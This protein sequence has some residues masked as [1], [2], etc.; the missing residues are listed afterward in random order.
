ME[1]NADTT[2]Q[3]VVDHL[4]ATLNAATAAG[5]QIFPKPVKTLDDLDSFVNVSDIL[6]GPGPGSGEI[7]LIVGTVET[8]RGTMSGEDSISRLPVEVVV[9]F[10]MLRA[11]LA[12]EKAAVLEAKRY[13]S[14]VQQAVLFDRS[15]NGNCDLIVWNG[16]IIS[17]TE[18]TGAVRMIGGPPNQMFYTVT[19]PVECGWPNG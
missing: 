7:G 15:R 5:G 1:V 2:A 6:S 16:R 19:I 17:G 9:R 11:P 14:I 10:A 13:G 12:D 4:I 18:S 8:Q 3:A